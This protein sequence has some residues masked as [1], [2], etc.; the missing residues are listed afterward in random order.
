MHTRRSTSA[1]RFFACAFVASFCVG[2]AAVPRG[3]VE[4]ARSQILA[5]RTELAQ[6]KDTAARLR[7]QNRDISARAV[8]D[9]RR[10][11]ALEDSVARLEASVAVYQ[12]EREKYAAAFNRIKSEI[13]SASDEAVRRQ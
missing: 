1:C 9:A 4:E 2:C 8:E 6:A 5:L 12:D 13:A 7:T 11:T 3:Q 10:I